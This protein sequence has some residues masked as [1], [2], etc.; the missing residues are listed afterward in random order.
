STPISIVS[1]IGNGAKHGV[2]IKGGEIMEDLGKVKVLA[3][4]KTGTLTEGKP[5]VTK[6]KSF[7]IND[8]DEDQLLKIAV[9]GEKYSE[10]PLAKA[11]IEAGEERLGSIEGEPEDSEIITGQGLKVKVEGKTYLIGNRKLLLE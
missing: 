2:L 9:I 3:F 5:K 7:N 8:I 4:D 6:V 11:I 10:H 1:G